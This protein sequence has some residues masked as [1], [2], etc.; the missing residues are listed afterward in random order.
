[1]DHPNLIY[2][3]NIK[4]EGTTADTSFDTNVKI[5]DIFETM[6]D[7]IYDLD[8]AQIYI[9]ITRLLKKILV[10]HYNERTVF[11][12]GSGSS[13]HAAEKI[14][15]TMTS[16]GIDA[17]AVNPAQLPHGDFAHIK[18][19]DLL[20][21][22]S[23]CGETSNLK[24]VYELARGKGVESVLITGNEYSYLAKA[25][26]GNYVIVGKNADDSKLISIPNQ[27]ILPSFLNLVVGDA[28]AV[29]LAW[30]IKTTHRQFAE[31][32]HRGGAVE[33]DS[34][35]YGKYLSDKNNLTMSY[36]GSN[37]TVKE[38]FCG[39]LEKHE[40]IV[41]TSFPSNKNNAL[42]ET[43]A[44]EIESY[45]NRAKNPGQEVMIFGMGPMGIGYIGRIMS[46]LNKELIY[47][48]KD[49]GKRSRNFVADSEKNTEVEAGD[50]LY[51][52]ET[53]R[54]AI[55]ALRI[56]VIFIA[57]GKD[58]IK[59]LI[60]A[61]SFIVLRRYA[62]N[63][64]VS[65]NFVFDENFQ[66]YDNTLELLR[67][68]I[69]KKLEDPNIKNYFNEFVGLVPAVNEAIVPEIK[70][71]RVKVEPCIAPLYID[72]S[73]WKKQ[74]HESFPEFNGSIQFTDNFTAMHMRKL[75]MHNMAHA[76]T[77]FLGRVCGYTAICDAIAD[78]NIET[79]VRSAM[80]KVGSALYR[81]WDYSSAEHPDIGSY[82]T[83][84]VE[85][86]KNSFLEDTVERV[87]KDPER[88]LRENDRLI[89]PLNYVYKYSGTVCE[90]ILL[91][92]AAAMRS[93]GDNYEEIKNT[94]LSKLQIGENGYDELARAEKELQK[95]VDSVKARRAAAEP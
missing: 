19:R 55:Y 89:G 85:K 83:W 94:V 39:I 71:G 41:H 14:A 47:V 79:K 72:R 20:I 13:L 24:Y 37:E 90:E 17:E 42:L 76:M 65:V 43:I 27:K 18:P 40:K 54:I 44:Q 2:D 80:A 48:E 87:A 10:S 56:D 35:N 67:Y 36:M 11:I 23:F 16:I 1:L 82:I 59:D 78:K 15:A 70:E 30:L 60:D 34:S 73:K 12:T 62:Y 29:L 88:K 26:E 8:S 46:E 95:L 33:R 69:Y 93:A 66:I 21:I 86:Y 51:A 22:I 28:V 91:G 31:L 45:I 7:V 9:Q 57:V 61:I 6:S 53:E 5:R 32:G 3:D 74:K 38:H 58:N 63:I 77:A 50:I 81:R 92:I 75:W 64:Q 84:C 25:H 49:A 68:E 4:Y 52:H